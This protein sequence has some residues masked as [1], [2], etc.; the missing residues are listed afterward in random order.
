MDEMGGHSDVRSRAL[1]LL[2]DSQG[3][4]QLR[5]EQGKRPLQIAISG[6]PL[7]WPPAAH[8]TVA[9]ICLLKN[10]FAKSADGL[11]SKQMLCQTG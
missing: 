10:A 4:H 6:F 2:D 1:T 9:S 8:P 11:P 7:Y 3:L 5:Q